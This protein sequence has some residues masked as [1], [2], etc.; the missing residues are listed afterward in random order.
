MSVIIEKIIRKVKSEKG[1]EV[2]DFEGFNIKI[3]EATRM[4]LREVKEPDIIVR[5]KMGL[6]RV[7]GARRIVSK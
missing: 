3:E 4:S 7:P 5:T 1:R 2:G 6:K